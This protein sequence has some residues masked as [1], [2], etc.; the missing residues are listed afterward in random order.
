MNR[1]ASF[2]LQSVVLF[3]PLVLGLAPLLLGALGL[4]MNRCHFGFEDGLLIL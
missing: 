4:T 3:A 1:L 2:R